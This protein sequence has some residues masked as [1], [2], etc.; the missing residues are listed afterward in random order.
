MAKSVVVGLPLSGRGRSSR[1]V[2]PPVAERRGFFH[3]PLRPTR[4]CPP[5]RQSRREQPWRVVAPCGRFSLLPSSLRQPVVL[6]QMIPT[7]G[8]DDRGRDN[9][10]RSL[11]G[12]DGHYASRSARSSWSD[13]NRG[14]IDRLPRSFAT[15][16]VRRTSRFPTNRPNDE[17]SSLVHVFARVRRRTEP[18]DLAAG[19]TRDPRQHRVVRN[20]A[21]RQPLARS[22]RDSA[23]IFSPA[24]KRQ[25]RERERVGHGR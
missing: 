7:G 6:S 9:Q 16:R 25:E 10:H 13:S 15:P 17:Q 18:I 1:G 21:S 12:R 14:L 8:C 5:H 23:P 22:L 19:N 2:V 11:I 24:G 20:S 4:H 3:I